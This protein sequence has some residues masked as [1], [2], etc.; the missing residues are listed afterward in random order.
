MAETNYDINYDDERFQQVEDDKEQA[1]ADLD[2]TYDDMIDGADDLYKEKIEQ[3]KKNEEI[4][5][6]LQNERTQHTIDQI[7]QQKDQANKDYIK[8]QS[9]AYTDWQ[10]QSNPYGAEAEKMAS[11]GLSNT[12][13]SESSQVAM[14]NTYQNRVATAREVYNR[15]VL[16]YDN[17]IKD[18]QLQNSSILAEIA[19]QAQAEQ[20]DL[21]IQGTLYKNELIR[22]K[23]NQKLTIDN[24]YW[25]RYL[26]VLDQINTENA[27]AE[28]VRQWNENMAEQKR[29]H[30]EDLAE[31]KRQ[32]DEEMAEKKRQH[33]EDLAETKR[34][35]DEKNKTSTSSSKSSSSKSSSAKKKQATVKGNDKTGNENSN[36]SNQTSTPKGSTNSMGLGLGPINQDT[37]A[38]LAAAGLV[39]VSK[40]SD[41]KIYYY[42]NSGVTRE[43]MNALL[44][45]AGY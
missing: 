31:Q 28:E 5:T 23:A 10:K 35:F 38:K 26:A 37:I 18:A 4:Q 22:E 17:A 12:G 36:S 42:N 27:L 2:D 8:E 3:S 44:K 30:D 19:A 9:G 7:N 45:L 6:N 34:Q 1:Y 40:G 25:N 11:S 32:H 14:Y 21:A 39:T 13:Y 29:Q 15:A 20:I 33:D 16:N 43:N 41:G 24:N